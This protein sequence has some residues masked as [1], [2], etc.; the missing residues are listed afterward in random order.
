MRDAQ[1]EEKRILFVS[2][3]EGD[4]RRYRCFHH[5]EQLALRNIQAEFRESVDPQLPVDVLN[6]D[7]FVLHRVPYSPLIGIVIN[8]AHLQG[9]PVIFETDDFVFA[10]ELYEQIGY[11]DTLSPEDARQF[12]Q[13][14]KRQA[15]TF[16]LCDCVLTTTE[17]LAG[18]ATRRGK[19]AYVHRNT[20]S[21]EMIRIS[22]QAFA[23][24]Q[25]QKKEADEKPPLVVAYFSGTGSHNRDFSV[26]T[27]PLVW[28]LETYPQVWLHISGHL[29]LDPEFS[30]FHSRIRR[31]PYIDW[32]ELPY[33]IAQVDINLAP[34]EIDN[35][36]CRAKSENKFVEAALVGVPTIASRIDAYELVIDNGQNGL[37]ASTTGE[38]KAALQ[39]L[40]NNPAKRQTLGAAAQH[41]VYA[42]YTP[43]QRAPDLLKTLEEIDRRYSD[44]SASSEAILRELA[45]GMNEYAAWM[46]SNVQSQEARLT[47]LR[48]VL[49]QYEDRI[50]HREQ[51]I[52][53]KRELVRRKNEVIAQ[54]NEIVRQKKDVIKHKDEVIKHK[55]E[56]IR[57]LEQRIEA[58]MQGR[59]MRLMTAT[60][61]CLRAITRK[62]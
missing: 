7:I 16:Q 27:E 24:R 50:V 18:E 8:M 44:P 11:V 55:D 29:E 15:E 12:H 38:W 20:P 30:P 41:T 42:Q 5:Q 56:V 43:E 57:K 36:F 52:E 25:R 21:D 17:F 34:L 6:Y 28:M 10:P 26:I 4:T 23:D 9:K 45:D 31:T 22:E 37:L 62:K 33:L 58:I 2:G 32:R 54:K 47:S 61:R 46:E 59:V 48:Q 1:T 39:T 19:Q 13:N 60:Q 49:R 35:P 14:L 3:T 51:I 53:H 40:L